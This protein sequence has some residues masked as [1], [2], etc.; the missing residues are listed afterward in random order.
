MSSSS[1]KIR[2]KTNEVTGNVKQGVGKAV[3]SD[4]LQLK[5]KVQELKGKG[6]QA[7]AQAKDAVNDA[8][9]RTR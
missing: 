5:G 7:V 4:K 9:K 1:D 8:T 3:G 6:Q 2:G